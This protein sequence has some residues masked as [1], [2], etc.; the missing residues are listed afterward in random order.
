[1]VSVK[2]GENSK[3]P[4]QSTLL[5]HKP[6]LSQQVW[7]FTVS[8]LTCGEQY[9]VDRILYHGVAW[10]VQKAFQRT[11]ECPHHPIPASGCRADYWAVH[12]QTGRHY[13]FIKEW[14]KRFTNFLTFWQYF[15]SGFK[16]GLRSVMPRTW[17][18]RLF[19]VYAAKGK[20]Q[21]GGQEVLQGILLHWEFQPCVGLNPGKAGIWS[22]L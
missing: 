12:T 13:I 8:L 18:P 15:S 11:Q 3:L 17:M 1:M 4:Q 19:L 2:R 9:E 10:G 6:S 16:L 7:K 21:G 5:L 20:L 22:D 14:G